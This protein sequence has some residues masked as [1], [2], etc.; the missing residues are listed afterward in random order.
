M[1]YTSVRKFG[2]PCARD[3]QKCHR[4]TKNTNVVVRR[5]T[6]NCY[7]PA[8][9]L[10]PIYLVPSVD[11]QKLGRTTRNCH[12]V[13]RGTTIY[14]SLIRTLYIDMIR[15]FEFLIDLAANA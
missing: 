6:I 1:V 2:C 15:L 10:D 5:T 13:V 11:N 12:L 8:V 4:T 7:A 3:N 14:F 9:K